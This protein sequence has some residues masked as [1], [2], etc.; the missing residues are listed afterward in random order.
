MMPKIKATAISVPTLDQ[1]LPACSSIPET[2]QVATPRAAAETSTRS[3]NL[4]N[5]ILLDFRRVPLRQ[6]PP[7]ALLKRGSWAA[8]YPLGAVAA[9]DHG[10]GQLAVAAGG[11]GDRG[12]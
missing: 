1:V 10:L 12:G 11:P 4:I 5:P 2:A 7:S 9:H 8:T 3:R 6:N